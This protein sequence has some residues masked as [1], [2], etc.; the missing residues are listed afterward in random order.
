MFMSEAALDKPP[1]FRYWPNR[2]Q[3]G[4]LAFLASLTIFFA[5]LILAYG[6]ILADRPRLQQ[7]DVPAALWWS[8]WIL[9]GS[10]VTLGLARWAVRRALLAS[11]RWLSVLTTLL[12]A[13]F[14]GSQLKASLDLA[15]QGLYVT[16]NPHGSMFYVFSG[17]HALHLVGGLAGLIAV[18]KQA[19]DLEDGEE[20]PLRRARG[21]AQMVAYYWNFVIVSWVVLFILLLRWV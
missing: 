19:F 3:F 1:R 20:S 15:A 16:A 9:C 5:S 8:T 21:R 11:Y 13:G 7:I 17:F 4:M 2:P 6:F 10:G 18:N 14:L 12:G